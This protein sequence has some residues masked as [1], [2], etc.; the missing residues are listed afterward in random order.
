MLVPNFGKSLQSF[1]RWTSDEHI[2]NHNRVGLRGNLDKIQKNSSFSSWNRPLM[3]SY[4]YCNS[5]LFEQL[6]LVSRKVLLVL[7]QAIIRVIRPACTQA[8]FHIYI[9]SR[10]FSRQLVLSIY[11]QRFRRVLTPHVYAKDDIIDGLV[12]LSH[13]SLISYIILA[14]LGQFWPF[15]C[16]MLFMAYFLQA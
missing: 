15:C 1:V 7:R 8:R 2:T 13:M 9:Y 6:W 5:L 12:P 16:V 4:F 14:C 11:Y 3:S 10:E